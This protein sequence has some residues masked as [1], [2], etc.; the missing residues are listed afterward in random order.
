MTQSLQI[1]AIIP[2]FFNWLE[3]LSTERNS[4]AKLPSFHLSSGLYFLSLAEFLLC[5]LLF[6]CMFSQRLLLSEDMEI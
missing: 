4:N 6:R 2:L 3:R 1:I 5:P